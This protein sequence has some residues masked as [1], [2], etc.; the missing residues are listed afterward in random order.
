MSPDPAECLC[1]PSE[2]QCAPAYIGPRPLV[3]QRASKPS[4]VPGTPRIFQKE[5]NTPRDPETA[6]N[7][8]PV[9]HNTHPRSSVKAPWRPDAHQ[10]RRGSRAPETPQNAPKLA[11]RR[12]ETGLV[13]VG[14]LVS[15][16]VLPFMAPPKFSPRGE[17]APRRQESSPMPERLTALNAQ[18]NSDRFSHYNLL[19]RRIK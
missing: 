18:L 6:P 15:F 13:E 2:T 10:N 17:G 12:M 5:N 8:P 16:R 11:A 19:S 3:F 1:T 4:G 9:Q 14:A 7:L